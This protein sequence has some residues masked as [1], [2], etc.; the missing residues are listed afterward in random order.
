MKR[1]AESQRGMAMLAVLMAV[2]L[3]TVL[4]MDFAYSATSGFRA[5]ANQMNELRADYLARSGV[6]VGLGL[7]S[8]DARND[9]LSQQPYDGL[10]EMWATP[11]PPLPVGGGTASVSIVDETRKL[12]INQLVNPANGAPNQT[13]AAELLRLFEVINIPPEILPA[14]I[15][16]LTPGDTPSPGGAKSDYYLGLIPPYEPRNGP[17]P[18]I[19]D[20]KMVRGVDDAI[21]T[22]L[23]QFLTVVPDTRVNIN[24]APPEVI[25]AMLPQLANQ[26]SML[27]AILSQRPFR[28]LTDFNKI[29]GVAAIAKNAQSLFTTQSDYFTITGVGKFAGARTFAYAT[30]RRNGVGPML[31]SFW[32]ED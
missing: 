27:Q 17:M 6:Q 19:A 24:T 31:L 32:H 12:G 1:I 14:L 25:L 20:L 10:D 29:P 5:A 4:V 9:A 13:F 7:L 16:W 26:P 2:A 21:F 23:A 15:D 22:R 3:M 28:T 11:F 8:Q 30:V 18:T